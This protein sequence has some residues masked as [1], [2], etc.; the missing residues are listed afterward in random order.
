MVIRYKSFKLL[1]KISDLGYQSQIGRKKHS[2]ATLLENQICEPRHRMIIVERFCEKIVEDMI[3]H[4]S[5]SNLKLFLSLSHELRQPV[6]SAILQLSDLKDIVLSENGNRSLVETHLDP[7]ISSQELLVNL[8]NDMLDLVQSQEKQIRFTFQEFEVRKIFQESLKMIS[9]QSLAKNVVPL[10]DLSP[11]MRSFEKISSDANR[12]R[13]IL[14]NLLSNANKFTL[15]GFISVLVRQV[16]ESVI[17]IGVLDSGIGIPESKRRMIFEA[18]NKSDEKESNA[19]N[20]QG[21]G[22]GNIFFFSFPPC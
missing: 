4:S 11:R 22:L 8:I 1:V 10:L 18:L 2:S 13:Q 6:K 3:S 17:Q 14:V 7:L 16:E 12:L 15:D 20:T 9:F 19:L 21:C 5:K